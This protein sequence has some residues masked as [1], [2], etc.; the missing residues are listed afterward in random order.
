MNTETKEPETAQQELVTDAME[1]DKDKLGLVPIDSEQPVA[2]NLPTVKTETEAALQLIQHV[3]SNPD[4]D[5]D[6]FERLIKWH[7]ENLDRQAELEFNASMAACQG[8]IE[9]VARGAFNKH[10]ESWYA[11]VDDIN[12][13][14]APIYSKHGFSLIFSSGESPEELKEKGFQRLY[15]DIRHRGGHTERVHSDLPIDDKGS[16]G[17]TNKT[18]IQGLTSTRTYS[19]KYMVTE[20]F[21]VALKGV[22]Q[23][24]NAPPTAA[25]DPKQ[26]EEAT[27]LL[28]S[29]A[30]KEQLN[31][32]FASIYNG[33]KNK[34]FR[35]EITLI[36]NQRLEQ[37]K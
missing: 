1:S 3:M 10:T 9:P 15:C 30:N 34:E 20:I 8:E 14:I 4:A 29:C 2:A 32:Q 37:L 21:N 22:D 33:N 36:K 24:G 18:Q 12:E 31:K 28:N 27:N 26:I 7:R 23:D 11:K 16:A 5:M 25:A 17:T 6:K 19:R 35:R 13:A